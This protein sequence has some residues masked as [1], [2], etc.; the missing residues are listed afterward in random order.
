MKI[1]YLHQYFKNHDIS[2]WVQVLLASK[3]NA[4]DFA[5]SIMELKKLIENKQ[6]KESYFDDHLKQFK[7]TGITKEYIDLYKKLKS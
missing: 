1:L 3:P 7:W 2:R 5:D 4:I 6:I